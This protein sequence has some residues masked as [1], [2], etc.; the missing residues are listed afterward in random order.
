MVV[1]HSDSHNQFL[2]V[3]DNQMNNRIKALLATITVVCG[4]NG[5]SKQVTY[6]V[7]VEPILKENCGKCHTGH[8]LGV[9]ASGFSLDS[10]ET[11]MQGSKL[12]P[13]IV[14]SS[15]TSSNLYL[16]VSGQT[17]TSSH[18]PHVELPLNTAHTEVIKIWIDQGAVK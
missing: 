10:Y 5:C 9:R 16:M 2:P 8:Q 17:D 1:T 12:G 3:E 14:A 11:L 13:V 7:N 4:L 6:A 18:M 15:S